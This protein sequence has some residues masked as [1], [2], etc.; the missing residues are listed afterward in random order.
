[1][2]LA[3]AGGLGRT[4]GRKQEVLAEAAGW[5][6]KTMSEIEITSIFNRDNSY[7]SRYFFTVLIFSL[8]Y[9]G[10]SKCSLSLV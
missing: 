5:Q 9:G 6:R 3:I 1:M 2:M 8:S 10:L 7:F 4:R